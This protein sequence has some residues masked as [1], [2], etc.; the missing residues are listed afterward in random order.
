MDI[1]QPDLFGADEA[2]EEI[3]Q[4]YARRKRMSA[5]NKAKE[6]LQQR[7]GTE[8]RKLAR[9]DAPATSKAAANAVRTTTAEAMVHRAIHGFGPNGCIVADLFEMASAGKLG[10]HAYSFTARVTGLKSKGFITA[11]PDT[12][13][14]PSG[15]QQ[16]VLR[17]V[18]D[19]LDVGKEPQ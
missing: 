5:A 2:R 3:R 7:Y 15:R 9:R 6:T 1:K 8:P 13:T 18:V 10:K 19:P 14:G 17:S 12:R 16:N 4:D 11:G